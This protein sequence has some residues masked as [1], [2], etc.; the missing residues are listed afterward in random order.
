VTAALQLARRGFTSAPGSAP[1]S[2]TV[3]PEGGFEV[4]TEGQRWEA[5]FNGRHRAIQFCADH[6]HLVPF[7]HT[8]IRSARRAFLPSTAP[9]EAGRLASE[10]Y[11]AYVLGL[12]ATHGIARF[13]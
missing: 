10:A 2:F 9:T 12:V 1:A 6:P 13:L 3:E 4:L 7:L 5:Q 11:C 8:K